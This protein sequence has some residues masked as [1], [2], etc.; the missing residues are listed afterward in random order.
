MRPTTKVAVATAAATGLVS[1]WS[2]ILFGVRVAPGV[3]VI[4]TFLGAL[5][6]VAVYLRRHWRTPVGYNLMA[7]AVVLLIE[8][9]LGIAAI[10]WGVNWPARDQI[11]IGAWALVAWVIWWRVGLLFAAGLGA[12]ATA[13]TDGCCPTCRQ[14][15]PGEHTSSPHATMDAE[16]GTDDTHQRSARPH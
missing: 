5:T 16:G 1:I 7:L 3:L 2:G 14:R 11:R 12:G 8:T 9:A 15:L 13:P 4:A 10:I 6:F